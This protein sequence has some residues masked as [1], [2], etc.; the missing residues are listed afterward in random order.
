MDTDPQ[1]ALEMAVCA[2][3]R[4][5]HSAFLSWPKPDRDKAIWWHVRDRDRCGQCGTRSAEW[6]ERRGGH[7]NAYRPELRRCRGCELVAAEQER[8]KNRTSGVGRGVYVTLVRR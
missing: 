8:L 1:L 3:Y 6:D 5:P 2:H 7:R 4:I